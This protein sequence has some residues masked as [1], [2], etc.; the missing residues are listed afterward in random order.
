MYL[1]LTLEKSW[2]QFKCHIM[3]VKKIFK[4]G[5]PLAS[6]LRNLSFR[7]YFSRKKKVK[8]KPAITTNNVHARTGVYFSK[9]L[10]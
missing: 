5:S 7:I 9:K 10:G 1:S 6:D 8:A 2:A 4:N 3:T